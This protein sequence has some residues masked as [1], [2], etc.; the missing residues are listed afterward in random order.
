LSGETEYRCGECDRRVRLSY[1]DPGG[2]CPH[3][4]VI[5]VARVSLYPNTN[6]SYVGKAHNLP[7][8]FATTEER[9]EALRREAARHRIDPRIF[10]AL[11]AGIGLFLWRLIAY[12]GEIQSDDMSG[13]VYIDDEESRLLFRIYYNLFYYVILYP[14]T[15]LIV[16]PIENLCFASTKSEL[17]RNYSGVRLHNACLWW[18]GIDWQVLQD[19]KTPRTART[20]MLALCARVGWAIR[21]FPLALASTVFWLQIPLLVFAIFEATA[22]KAVIEG[23]I[24]S[25]IRAH[26]SFPLIRFLRP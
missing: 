23:A 14:A 15:W 5:W 12:R 24:Q 13:E 1:N 22:H 17:T 10:F 9:I 8:R 25:T 7:H 4:G 11:F 26:E 3:C 19:L 16:F 20:R 2:I 18:R 6:V 21:K